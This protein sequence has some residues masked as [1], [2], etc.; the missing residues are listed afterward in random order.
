MP[1]RRFEHVNWTRVPDHLHDQMEG[2]LVD[3]VAPASPFLYA[4]L[5]ND[6]IEAV[7]R[8]TPIEGAMLAEIVGFLLTDCPP[9]CF[10][11]S[12]QVFAWAEMGGWAGMREQANRVGEIYEQHPWRGRLWKA[13]RLE[14]EE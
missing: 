5:R 14:D 4:V 11:N 7:R 10:G 3:G 1:L 9:Q 2:W 12:A 13:D 6:L 8:A